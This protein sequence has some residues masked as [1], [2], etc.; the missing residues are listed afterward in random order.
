MKNRADLLH[1]AELRLSNAAKWQWVAIFL[2]FAIAQVFFI[3]IVFK[4]ARLHAARESVC[5]Q[6]DGEVREYFCRT[7]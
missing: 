1:A 5:Q 6:G 2:L 7:H 4:D 3:L